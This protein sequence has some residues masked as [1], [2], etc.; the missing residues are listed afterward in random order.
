MSKI[1]LLVITS[2]FALIGFDAAAQSNCSA[3]SRFSSSEDYLEPLSVEP[4]KIGPHLTASEYSQGVVL[5]SELRDDELWVDVVS[6][7]GSTSAAV[8]PSLI[9]RIGR[10]ANNDFEGLV[11]AH[12]GQGLFRIEREDLRKI[13]CQF[14]WGREGGEN[15]IALMRDLYKAL[16][17][18]DSGAPLSRAFNG[19]LLGDTG[20]TM[21]LNNEVVLPAW[22]LEDI[23]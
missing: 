17:Y 9:M 13:G 2:F 21:R 3:W 23:K 15:P 19:N 22:I 18:Y 7:P 14:I 11:L 8:A 10:L 12:E 5:T 6:F 16:T 1:L 20:L 4:E